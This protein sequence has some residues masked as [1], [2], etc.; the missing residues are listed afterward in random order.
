MSIGANVSRVALIALALTPGGGLQA[1]RLEYVGGGAGL[2]VPASSFG[3]VDKAGWHVSGLA[4]GRLKGSVRFV[5]DA[6]YGQ[7]T[8]RDGVAG[9]STL[10]GGTIGAALFLAADARRVR[11]FVSAG[12]G[13]F[14]ANVDV[15]GYGSAAATKLAPAGGVGLL[16]GTG[17]RRGL[18]AAR[19]VSVGTSPQTTSFISVSAGVILARGSP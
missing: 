5:I 9:R 18:L 19:Y 7:T 17:R 1:Q 6:T 8:H 4:I 10:A 11:P 12:V 13:V 2:V 3:D 16:L 14:R 15:P